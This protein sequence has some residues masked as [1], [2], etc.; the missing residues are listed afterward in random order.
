VSVIVHVDNPAPHGHSPFANP[1]EIDVGVLRPRPSL[2]IDV[3]EP[4][5]AEDDIR[6]AVAI[7]IAATA[8]RDG[9]VNC[10]ATAIAAHPARWS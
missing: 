10:A 9:S 8:W 2:A 7:D 6:I 1:S 4:A 3:F 5:S